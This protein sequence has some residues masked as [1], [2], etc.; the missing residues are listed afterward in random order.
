MEKCLPRTI[1]M[2]TCFSP[3]EVP[4]KPTTIRRKLIQIGAYCK[5]GKIFDRWGKEIYFYQV[6]ESGG[7]YQRDFI[8]EAPKDESHEE[9]DR[10]KT[11]EKRYR[12]IKMY[13]PDTP[14]NPP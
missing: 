4:R 7:V 2:D 8:R 1:S 12:V 6:P 5:N 11:L 9:E 3:E 14:C 13:A 10:L